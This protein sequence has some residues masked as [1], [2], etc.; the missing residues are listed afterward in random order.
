MKAVAS[1]PQPDSTQP[2]SRTDIAAAAGAAARLP[3]A[4]MVEDIVGC[5]WSLAVLGAVKSGVH[6]PGALEHAIQGL[7]KKVLNER[8]TKLVRFGILEKHS[9]AELPPRV[10]YRLTGFGLKFCSLLDNIEALERELGEA[11]AG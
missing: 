8:L 7:S 9:Y 1:T 6:R 11:R 10:E 3:V 5:K 4:R 2:A